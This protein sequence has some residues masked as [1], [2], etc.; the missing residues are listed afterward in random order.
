MFGLRS[1]PPPHEWVRACTRLV[2]SV[3]ALDFNDNRP[4]TGWGLAQRRCVRG[5]QAVRF[6]GASGTGG[7]ECTAVHQ[8]QRE[9]GALRSPR[10]LFPHGTGAPAGPISNS[11]A[12]PAT[13]GEISGSH[14][15][16]PRTRS[17]C[18]RG[19]RGKARA[20][21]ANMPA[22]RKPGYRP[23]LSL[24]TPREC[25]CLGRPLSHGCMR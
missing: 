8:V 6:E 1:V 16:P 15:G 19:G 2:Q 12:A 21:P 10:A 11:C 18:T 17:H 24:R 7:A 9:A 20:E 23:S 22:F 14:A 4:Q 5:L 3:S 13:V 25:A